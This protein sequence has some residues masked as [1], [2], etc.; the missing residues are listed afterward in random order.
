[1]DADLPS[2]AIV[3]VNYNGGAYISA[4]LKS[5]QRLQ[6]SNW[7]LIVV[8]CASC[9]GSLQQIACLE[10]SDCLIPLRDN[11]G[12]TGGCNHGIRAALA[13]GH[14]YVLFLNPDT[15]VEPSLLRVLVSIAERGWIATPCV[16]LQGSDR[17]MDDTAGDFDWR[18]GI[19]QRPHYGHLRPPDLTHVRRVDMASLTCLLVPAA[20]LRAL[21]G[22]TGPYMDARYFM[23]YDDFDFVRRLQDLGYRVV[24]TPDAVVYHRKSA[25]G[26]GVDSPFKHYYATRNRLLLM[27][28]VSPL[29]AFFGFLVYFL[30]GRL[31]RMAQF[32]AKGRP[33]VASAILRGVVDFLAGRTGR[34]VLPE[35]CSR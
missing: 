26:G 34:T 31:I 18:R 15:V 2:V 7:H 29:P 9:D 27:L 35:G 23:Y 3:T 25:A 1:M 8:D 32:I 28:S 22:D 33:R 16:M 10:P 13:R 4:F 30:C 20:A 24:Y 6:Y 21:G 14:D 19:W 12:I 11:L 5:L 17:L